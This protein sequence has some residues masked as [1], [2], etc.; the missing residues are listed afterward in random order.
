M[1]GNWINTYSGRQ[2]WP[3]APRV[4]DVDIVDIA[5]ALSMQCRFT[6]H[7]REFYSVADH[8]VRV[9][10][11][12]PPSD[13]LWALLHDAPEAYLID[14]ARPVKHAPQMAGYRDAETRLMLVIAERFGLIGPMP[15]SVIDADNR[16]LITEAHALMTMH[17][18]WL[19]EAPW[20]PY[21]CGLVPR[22]P[23]IAKR[24]FLKLFRELALPVLR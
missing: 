18:Q 2:F 9:A 13:K 5:H 14:L 10:E 24:D 6:G 3:L 12:V 8:C 23:E 22:E 11:R 15:A 17:P 19:V 7:V 4:E 1:S 16:M 20:K 21:D